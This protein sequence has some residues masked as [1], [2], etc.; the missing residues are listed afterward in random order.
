LIHA[1]WCQPFDRQHLDSVT[2]LGAVDLLEWLNSQ[3]R[4][5]G[6]VTGHGKPLRF[7]PQAELPAE[8]AYETWIAETGA[9]PT[10]DNSH[11][12]Y[13]ALIWLTYPV[14]KAN[15]NALQAAEIA[16]RGTSGHRGAARDAATIWDENLA[17]VVATQDA[18]RLQESLRTHDWR[19]LFITHRA[20]WHRHWH[21]RL[22]GHALLEKLAAPYNAI[23]AHAI[24]EPASDGFDAI[25]D[26]Q[27]SARIHVLMSN[28]AYCPLPVMGIPGWHD[29]NE[30]S[31][32]YADPKVFRPM[33]RT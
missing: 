28:N 2:R 21:V 32:F 29:G 27:L 11:D 1:P 8:T 26:R 23:T 31:G 18:D 33:P 3:A 10:R 24:V 14:T 5:R 6:I 19:A 7:V 4:S 9:V 15:L 16:Q 22:F 17:V 30:D 13:N 25:L 12:R 20:H